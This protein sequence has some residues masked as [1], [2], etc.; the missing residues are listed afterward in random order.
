MTRICYLFIVFVLLAAC[1]GKEKDP[2]DGVICDY[3]PYVLKF[4]LI[5]PG[6]GHDLV[7]GPHARIPLDSIKVQMQDTAMKVKQVID[8]PHNSAFLYF[9]VMGPASLRIGKAGKVT[10]DKMTF[11]TRPVGCCGSEIYSM[12]LNDNPVPVP[13]DSVG[14]YQVPYNL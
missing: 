7:Y 4:N 3:M 6:T 13:K 10:L 8:T 11:M 1:Q 9:I 2:C 12:Q 5:E 14:V